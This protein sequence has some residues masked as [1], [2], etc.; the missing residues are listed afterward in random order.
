MFLIRW[1]NAKYANEQS[2]KEKKATVKLIEEFK[3]NITNNIWLEYFN[4][5]PKDQKENWI[6]FEKE[7]C[8]I[9]K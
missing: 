1:F 9:I 5:C 7:I 2:E 3:D 4:Q 6:D 8:E